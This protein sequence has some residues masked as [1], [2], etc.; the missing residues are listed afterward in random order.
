MCRITC[1]HRPGGTRPLAAEKTNSGC[2]TLSGCTKVKPMASKSLFFKGCRAMEETVTLPLNKESGWIYEM[3]LHPMALI[4]NSLLQELLS[5]YLRLYWITR[6][7]IK[8]V[9]YYLSSSLYIFSLWV[10]EL[11]FLFLQFDRRL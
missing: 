4:K 7:L 1:D 11:F 2:G 6:S 3:N 8:T 9:R 10:L 5:F